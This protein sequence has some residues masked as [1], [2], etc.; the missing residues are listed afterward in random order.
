M[1]NVGS[2]EHHGFRSKFVQIGRVNLYASVTSDRVRSLLIRQK[3]DQIRFSLRRHGLE[4]SR[5][6][7]ALAIGCND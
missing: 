5:T 1:G 6:K 4:R 3:E 7:S 2:L